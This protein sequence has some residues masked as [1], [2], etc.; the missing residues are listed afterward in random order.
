MTGLVWRVLRRRNTS[1][2]RAHCCYIILSTAS[3]QNMN[4]CVVISL[5]LKKKKLYVAK[6][7]ECRKKKV[8][9]F[10]LLEREPQTPFSSLGTPDFLSTYLRINSLNNIEPRSL[11]CNLG[12]CSLSILDNS[13]VYM[14]TP[15]S[16]T[17]PHPIFRPGNRCLFSEVCASLF[18][19]CK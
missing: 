17:N 7:K 6:T 5:G 13:S 16:L 19:L 8:S 15:N 18:L 4:C 14:S 10:L 11:F 1:S 2:S 12:T 9:P 3:Q